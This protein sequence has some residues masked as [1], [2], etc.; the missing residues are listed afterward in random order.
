VERNGSQ[1]DSR[2]EYE[3]E[4]RIID[5]FE[6]ACTP[7]R[8]WQN[9]KRFLRDFDAS[10]EFTFDEA[11]HP[12]TRLK[13]DQAN[14]LLLLLGLNAMDVPAG[15]KIGGVDKAKDYLRAAKSKYPGRLISGEQGD[16][17]VAA[18]SQLVN[19]FAI[20]EHATIDDIT[21]LFG[22]NPQAGLLLKGA[23][24]EVLRASIEG[25]ADER[26][27]GVGGLLDEVMYQDHDR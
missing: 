20:R 21:M 8:N 11:V 9:I 15:A 2:G 12:A 3:Y 6:Y 10:V 14:E 5:P 1:R 24:A 22:N 13:I 19:E 18:M 16:K 23:V 4:P 27:R 26:R 7:P 17:R 25:V